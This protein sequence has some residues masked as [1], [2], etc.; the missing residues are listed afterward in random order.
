MAT[1]KAEFLSHYWDGRMRPRHAYA[2]GLI[3]QWTR[4]AR[5]M[6]GLVN[7]VTQTPGLSH[8]AKLAA[9]MPMQ[10][11]IP[12]FAPESFQ[13]WFKKHRENGKP[14]GARGKVILWPDTFNNHFFPETA[15]AAVEVLEHAGYQVEVP[16]QHVC[17]GRPLYDYGFLDL[18][19]KYLERTLEQ[20]APEIAAETPFVVLEPSCA[21]VFRDEI[22][23]LL[24]ERDDAHKLMENTFVLSEFLEKKA[25]HY[26][27]PKLKRKAILHGHCHQKAIIR[28]KKEQPVLKKMELQHELLTSG[29][30]GMAGSFGFEKDKYEVSVAVGEHS[31]LPAVRKASDTTIV[32][33]DGFSCREQIM[34]QTDRHALHL[35][36]VM[37]MAIRHGADGP[38]HGR[39]EKELVEEHERAVKRSM[40]NAALGV[41]GFAAAFALGFWAWKKWS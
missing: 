15:R 4:I 6:P 20:F 25:E 13:S 18:A 26:E 10:R 41:G 27:V 14:V 7:L 22:N 11:Q 16:Q 23:G 17:C 30:C 21:T 33:A 39:P 3:D 38:H 34:Q 12:A 1:Y 36:E 8:I 19:K 28:F 31:L 5:L 2:F 9:G 32:I 37:Q 35:A 24:S 40:R 29:C